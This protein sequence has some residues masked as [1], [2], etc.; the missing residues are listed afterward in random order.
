MAVL[1]MERQ[2]TKEEAERAEE[3]ILAGNW[4]SYRG[5][6]PQLELRDFY[7]TI[8]QVQ[9]KPKVTE[10]TWDQRQSILRS[11]LVDGARYFHPEVVR[12]IEYDLA[13]DDE[14][15]EVGTAEAYD[16]QTKQHSTEIIYKYK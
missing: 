9:M 6:N 2:Y 5:T 3:W 16:P 11:R 7:P 4:K 12:F 14:F 10:L 13:T 8:E 1:L 15:I